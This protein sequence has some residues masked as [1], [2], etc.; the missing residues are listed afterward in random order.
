MTIHHNKYFWLFASVIISLA[1]M[2]PTLNNQW[3]NWDD[4][5]YVLNNTLV[6]EVSGAT[7]GTMF[8]TPQVMGAYTPLVLLSWALDYSISGANAQVFHT[9]NLLYH[10]LN[11]ALV[12]WL[13]FLLFGRISVATIAALLF[14]LHPMHLEAVAWISARKDLLYTLFYLLSLL[15]YVYYT[16]QERRRGKHYLL[17]LLFFVL[18][19]L[20]KGVA[21]TLPVVLL[22]VDYLQHRKGW[23]KVL[24]EKVPMFALSIG[25]GLLAIYAQQE[26]EAMKTMAEHSFGENLLVGFYGTMLYLIKALI[27][28]QLSAFHPYPFAAGAPLPWF[29]YAAIVPVLALLYLTYRFRKHRIVAF[30]VLFFLITIAPV[31]QVLSFGSSVIADRF[32]Y[33]PYLGLF[34][35]IAMAFAYCFKSK[36]HVVAKIVLVAYLAVLGGF[37]YTHSSVWKN[38]EQLWNN[39]IAQYPN[40]FFGYV[41][42]GLYYAANGKPEQAMQ[43]YSKS[44]ELNPNYDMAHVNLGLF[45]MEQRNFASAL[46]HFDKAIALSGYSGAHA[47]RGLIYLNMSKETEALNDFNAAIEGGYNDA[48]VYYNRGLLYKM[49]GQRNEALADFN[50]AIALGMHHT[51]IFWDRGE[52]LFQMGN[53]TQALEDI[54]R[55]LALE[56]NHA[57]ALFVRG[58]IAM[59]QRQLDAA[60]ND[61][62]R[63]IKIDHYHYNAYINRGL[64][65]L[66]TNQFEAATTDFNWAIGLQPEHYLG[67]FNRGL[68]Y[69]QQQRYEIALSDLSKAIERAPNY[70]AAYVERAKVYAAME[71]YPLAWQ[72]VEQAQA[73]NHP[74]PVEFL[75]TLQPQ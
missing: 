20:S 61:F 38:G 46:L 54:N 72:D 71:Q 4:D 73:L 64:V 48:S 58:S 55:C 31:L 24:L 8:T 16:K 74:V 33:L 52:L 32:T 56:P 6:H 51:M 35:L 22:L 34:V 59:Q 13:I 26:G 63:C 42:R 23:R 5:D 62:N 25:F 37:T 75:N 1:T 39:T 44:I 57:D 67:F 70:G 69:A 40:D 29:I 43:D 36:Y 49:K 21:V 65:L 27:P 3:V 19:L 12:Y 68:C 66:N 9:T 60:L 41:K 11:V 28:Y 50:Q 18:A 53:N 15:A 10:L 7:I 14:G 45:Y 47:N 17:C 30:G 2:W